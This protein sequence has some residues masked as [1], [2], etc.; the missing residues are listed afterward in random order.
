MIPG[1]VICAFSIIMYPLNVLFIDNSMFGL[2][3]AIIVG[4][5][6]FFCY[7]TLYSA[8][9]KVRDENSTTDTDQQE[10]NFAATNP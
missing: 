4:I 8:Y 10:S 7:L 1:V 2:L 9:V 3:E 5:I 6:F